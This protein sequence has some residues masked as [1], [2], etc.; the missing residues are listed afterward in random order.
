MEEKPSIGQVWKMY[1]MGGITPAI[2]SMFNVRTA[3]Q[4]A[5]IRNIA[6]EQRSHDIMHVP[7][8]DVE[9]VVFDLETTGFSP[10]H[11]DE[12]ISIGAVK[13]TGSR[14]WKNETFYSVVNPKRPISR[15]IEELTGIT[16]GMAEAAPDL[17]HSLE[18]FFAFVGK[19]ILVAHG[20]GHDK[21][22]LNSALWRTSRVNLTHRILDTMFFERWLNP[23]RQSI[24]LDALID[25]YEIEKLERHHA[26]E[27]ARMTAQL[28]AY[29]LEELMNQ[30]MIY[31]SDLYE[32]VSSYRPNV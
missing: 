18:K 29:Q 25:A 31:L 1:K 24:T 10:Y 12:I 16:N 32:R 5:F 13:M 9:Y 2:T 4:M 23:K 11:G 27:D 8:K 6:K 7:L 14:I 22:F 21:H 28:W 26:L 17:I 20:T 19:S 15:E 3:Q 30:D